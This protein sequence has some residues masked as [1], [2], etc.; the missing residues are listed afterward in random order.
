MFLKIL[1]KSQMIMLYVQVDYIM[2]QRGRGRTLEYFVRW[3]GFGDEED[4]W[5]P[6]RNLKNAKRAV[7]DFLK[8][9]TPSKVYLTLT[10]I[11]VIN[12]VAT[13]KNIP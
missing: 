6:A 4:S 2:D 1:K 9:K 13:R 5:E 11:L 3:K 10:E 8:G 7:D 12:L